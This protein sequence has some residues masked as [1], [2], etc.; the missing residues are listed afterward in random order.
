MIIN[1]VDF[2]DAVE[3]LKKSFD[4]SCEVCDKVTFDEYKMKMM[5]IKAIELK[6]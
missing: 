3:L 1:E 4:E 2:D 5:L 6:Y